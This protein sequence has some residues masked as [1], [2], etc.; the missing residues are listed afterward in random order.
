MSSIRKSLREHS[1]GLFFYVKDYKLILLDIMYD[2]ILVFFFEIESLF[3]EGS[4]PGFGERYASV[5][6]H[7]SSL[8]IGVGSGCLWPVTKPACAV[9]QKYP[10]I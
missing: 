3:E 6:P 1:L 9:S 8:V 5:F 2:D 4:R 10:A 7:V